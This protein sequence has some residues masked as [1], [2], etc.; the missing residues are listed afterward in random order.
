[1]CNDLKLVR[2]LKL[3]GLCDNQAANFILIGED[4]AI[5]PLHFV[6]VVLHRPN[7]RLG[8]SPLRIWYLC[9]RKNLLM[10][11]IFN[12]KFML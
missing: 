6:P 3:A 1:M 10:D 11:G 9:R 2:V 8:F 5:L 4:Y 7:M 12:P